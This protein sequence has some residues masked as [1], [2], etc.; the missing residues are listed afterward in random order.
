MKDI[1]IDLGRHVAHRELRFHSEL[2]IY[3]GLW[4]EPKL[5]RGHAAGSESEGG[6]ET[7]RDVASTRPDV[8]EGAWGGLVVETPRPGIASGRSRL[9][10]DANHLAR[11]SRV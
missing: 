1:G 2:D 7:S 9:G 4:G 6:V 3:G 8:D 11:A 10:T 5:R